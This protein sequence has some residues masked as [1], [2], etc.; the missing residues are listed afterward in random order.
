[1]NNNQ[2]STNTKDFRSHTNTVIITL[3]FFSSLPSFAATITYESD[4]LNRLQTVNYGN[5]SL[6]TY[7]HDG[8]G[9][10][11]SLAIAAG[12]ADVVGP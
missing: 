7:A 9:N 11:T 6:E 10:R 8:T 2:H 12:Q 4:A 5:G 3:L 1:M